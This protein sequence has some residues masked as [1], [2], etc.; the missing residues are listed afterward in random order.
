MSSTRELQ[1]NHIYQTDHEVMPHV[2]ETHRRLD[3]AEYYHPKRRS[4]F[5]DWIIASMSLFTPKLKNLSTSPE[6]T[7]KS[8]PLF[9]P[10]LF[11]TP[12]LAKPSKAH[13]PP[14]LTH[15]SQWLN[16]SDAA[17]GDGVRRAPVIA[18][19]LVPAKFYDGVAGMGGG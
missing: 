9:L 19:K 18:A 5:L 15:A 1:N 6:I 12:R 4:P 2:S 13:Q 14:H 3:F 10:S 7:T 8:P 11:F 16:A 17:H